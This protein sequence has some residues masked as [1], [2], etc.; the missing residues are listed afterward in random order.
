MDTA[1]HL[2]VIPACAGIFITCKNPPKAVEYVAYKTKTTAEFNGTIVLGNTL[3]KLIP[4]F[5]IF[6]PPIFAESKRRFGSD[7]ANNI[8]I[9]CRAQ[10]Y[11]RMRKLHLVQSIK[12]LFLQWDILSMHI[13]KIISML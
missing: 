9:T 5:R 10:L 2:F 3:K 1:I 4:D 6:I 7:D 8:T 12:R 11:W 13:I